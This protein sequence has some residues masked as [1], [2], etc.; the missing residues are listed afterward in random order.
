QRS[1]EIDLGDW[2]PSNLRGQSPRSI[3]SDR[4]LRRQDFQ[5]CEACRPAG[6]TTDQVRTGGEPQDRQ[7]TRPRRAADAAATRRRGDRMKRREFI[8]TLGGAAIAWP[9]V[10]GAQQT[11]GRVYRVGYFG[12]T[13]RERSLHLM[14]AFEEGL[15]SLGYRLG[16]NVAIE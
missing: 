14:R 8:V 11:A 10:A 1:D 12:I 4:C 5:G 16:E 9:L 15:R 3:S 2:P 13:S 6:R 7:G